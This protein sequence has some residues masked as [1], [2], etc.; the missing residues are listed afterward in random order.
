MIPS[1]TKCLESDLGFGFG[2]LDLLREANPVGE[3]LA[4]WSLMG[5]PMNGTEKQEKDK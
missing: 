5:S 1:I 3:I 4:F 2:D